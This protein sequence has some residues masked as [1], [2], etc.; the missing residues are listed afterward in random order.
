[1]ISFIGGFYLGKLDFENPDVR[2]LS[3]GS[4]PVQ[5]L[6]SVGNGRQNPPEVVNDVDS[7]ISMMW[8]TRSIPGRESVLHLFSF[9]DR[10]G[11]SASAKEG[12][13]PIQDLDASP[14]SPASP[15]REEEE[16]QPNSHLLR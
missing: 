14:T 10:H 16:R 1:M 7:I 8:T 3:G 2:H 9:T 4:L 6:G 11:Q 13:T 15:A 5:L 12:L